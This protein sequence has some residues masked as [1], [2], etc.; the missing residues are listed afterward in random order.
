ME[1][2]LKLIIMGN[3]LGRG[4]TWPHELV[5]TLYSSRREG[6]AV[7]SDDSQGSAGRG[8]GGRNG[9]R[10]EALDSF[11]Q[12]TLWLPTGSQPKQLLHESVK[13]LLD[14]LMDHSSDFVRI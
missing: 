13:W 2:K 5:C 8:R 12:M 10:G 6:A 9:L 7:V 3:L 14:Q 4:H 1:L 11:G